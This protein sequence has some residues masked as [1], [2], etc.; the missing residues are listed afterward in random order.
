MSPDEFDDIAAAC[1]V[2]SIDAGAYI[3]KTGTAGDSFYIVLSGEVELIAG[4][5][6]NSTCMIGRIGQGGH[7]GESSLMTGEARSL[8]VRAI[9]DVMLGRFPSTLRGTG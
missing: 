3:Y 2:I 8:S 7:F 5:D 6:D 4:R 1:E 9:S